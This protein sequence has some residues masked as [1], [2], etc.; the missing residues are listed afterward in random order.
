MK[1]YTTIPNTN[2]ILDNLTGEKI[3]F[4]KNTIIKILNQLNDKNDELA[5]ELYD[6]KMEET[7]IRRIL[8][9]YNIHNSKKLDQ[10]LLNQRTW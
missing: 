3:S 1:R 8:K 7:E 9:K 5:T 6:N 4:K 2:I 10:C